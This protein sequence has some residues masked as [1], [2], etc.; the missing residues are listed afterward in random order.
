MSK[1]IHDEIKKLMQNGDGTT[2]R[3]LERKLADIIP[4]FSAVF[5]ALP[6]GSELKTMLN[7]V[8]PGLIAYKM[9]LGGLA[10]LME[11]NFMNPPA[12]PPQTSKQ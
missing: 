9:Q 10:E 8:T 12:P 5:N 6:D 7:V 11:N 2:A 1:I 4:T 3:R